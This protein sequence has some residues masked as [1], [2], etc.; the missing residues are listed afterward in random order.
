MKERESATALATCKEDAQEEYLRRWNKSCN[1]LD[2]KDDCALPSDTADYVVK[3]RQ[4]QI[5]DC[6]KQYPQK[7]GTAYEQRSA[8]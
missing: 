1:S 5:D 3:R 2:E 7:A 6:F 8:L 4:Q